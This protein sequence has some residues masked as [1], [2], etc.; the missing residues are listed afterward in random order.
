M[1]FHIP[2]ITAQTCQ[3]SPLQLSLELPIKTNHMDLPVCT[4]SDYVYIRRRRALVRCLHSGQSY[5]P[6]CLTVG[7]ISAA[8]MIERQLYIVLWPPHAH[9][10]TQAMLPT[11]YTKETKAKASHI[12]EEVSMCQS[13][14][15]TQHFVNI[16]I[17]EAGCAG[18]SVIHIFMSEWGF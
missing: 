8:H 9:S 1:S 11:T 6:S 2:G 5:L 14:P 4:I 10:G 15:S 13:T 12:C 3:V 18:E 7:S 17:A 16:V